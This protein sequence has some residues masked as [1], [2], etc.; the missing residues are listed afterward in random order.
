MPG[1]SISIFRKILAKKKD[2]RVKPGDDEVASP[3]T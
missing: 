2:H 1:K 3:S